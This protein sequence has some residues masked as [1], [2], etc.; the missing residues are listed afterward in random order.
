VS[1]STVAEVREQIG[2][3]STPFK[4]EELLKLK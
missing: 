1:E 2:D 3:R 4:E